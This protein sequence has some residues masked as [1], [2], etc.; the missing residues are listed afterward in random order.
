M[1]WY[2]VLYDVERTH[3]GEQPFACGICKRR[4]SCYG[5]KTR[6]ERKHS[7]RGSRLHV[8]D[9]ICVDIYVFNVTCMCSTFHIY[10]FFL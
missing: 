2:D 1:I 6:H 7:E 10:V 3:S 9:I 4:F 5:N 8:C